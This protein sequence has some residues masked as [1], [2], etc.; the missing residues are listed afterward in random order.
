MNFEPKE[1]KNLVTATLILLGLLSIFVLAKA[2]S[3][4]KAFRYIGGGTQATNTIAFS[5]TGEVTAIP[6]VATITLTARERGTTAKEAEGKVSQKVTKAM[7]FLKAQGVEEKDIKTQGYNSYPQYGKGGR[8]EVV[9]MSYGCQPSQNIIG[10]ETTQTITVKVR[11]VDNSGKIIEGITGTGINEIS[12]PE[13]T[14]DD[15][16]ALQNEARKKAI[17]DAKEK[18]RTLS[19]DLGVRLVRIVSFNE[20]GNSPVY[21]DMNQAKNAATG[22]AP[23]S[24]PNLP[25]GENTI[26][27]TVTITYEIR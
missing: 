7:D 2:A 9:C 19:R 21:Y 22:A 4:V 14:L 18:A 23:E 5:G 24:A 15:P 13:F 11:N 26:T 17:D 3:E 16:D 27:S 6:D 1:K 8:S 12:G 10:Y 25:K 20:N